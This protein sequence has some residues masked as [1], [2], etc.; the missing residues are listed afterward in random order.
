MDYYQA[1]VI[2]GLKQ[3]ESVSLAPIE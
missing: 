1:E 2:S 3:G